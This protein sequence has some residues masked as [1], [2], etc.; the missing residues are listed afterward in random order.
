MPRPEEARGHATPAERLVGALRRALR[1]V[2]SGR[3][4][5][6]R[7]RPR[8]AARAQNPRLIVCALT[9]YGQTGRSPS[10][11]GTTSNYLA[12]AGVLGVQGPAGGPPQVPR[13]PARGRQR[14]AV[15][16]DRHPRRARRAGAHRARARARRRDDRGVAGLRHRRASARRFAGEPRSAATRRSPAASRPTRRT[17]RRTATPSP[18][19]RSSRSSGRRSARARASRPT[20]RARSPARTRRHQGEGRGASSRRERARSGWRSAREHDC[21]V[22]PVLEPGGAPR[23]TRT[24]ARGGLLRRWIAVGRDRRRCARPLTPTDRA[25]TP[26]PR[27][28]EHTRA[29]LRE[30]GLDEATV[31]RLFAEGAAR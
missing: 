9:G 10:A 22:E 2:P 16:R 3:A 17:S 8:D 5:S 23:A 4:R 7:P 13:L 26:P 12:R 15:V 1:P 27:K 21:C 14:R 18:S 24:S 30:A 19:A 28:G 29:I 25:H 20:W 11:P 31:D 6:P